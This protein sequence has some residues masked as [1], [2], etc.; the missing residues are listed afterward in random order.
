MRISAQNFLCAP[1]KRQVGWQDGDGD[2]IPLILDTDPVTALNDGTI[3]GLTVSYSGDANVNPRVNLNPWGQQHNISLNTI[4]SVEYRVDG[5]PWVAANPSDG[6]FDTGGENYEFTT[7]PLAPGG[8]LVEARALS[9]VGNTDLSFASDSVT[10]QPVAVPTGTTSPIHLSLTPNPFSSS[11]EISYR[12]PESG[13]A[14]VRVHDA[15]G[16]LV[17]KQHVTSSAGVTTWD[18]VGSSGNRQSPGVYFVTVRSSGSKIT[19][20]VVLMR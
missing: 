12:V 8:H 14:E 15:Q 13:S 18:G 6:A 1:T 20:E 10:I 5:G 7:Q 9:N 4:T 2:G 17:W 19:R 11:V 16:R 3:V